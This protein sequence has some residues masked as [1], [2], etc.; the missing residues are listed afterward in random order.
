[1]FNAAVTTDIV[2]RTENSILLIKRGKAPYK[3]MWALPGGYLEPDET[4][5]MC[6]LRELQEETGISADLQMVGV[7]STPDRDPRERTVTVVF[8]GCL[9]EEM[10]ATGG[11]DAKEARWWPLAEL[12]YMAFDHLNII[13]GVCR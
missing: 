9:E 1:M 3:D 13:H 5:D 12:P 6:A 7:V 8:A 2:L 11:D 4:L 10:E